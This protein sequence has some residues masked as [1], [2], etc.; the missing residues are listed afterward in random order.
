LNNR[1]SSKKHNQTRRDCNKNSLLGSICILL[2]NIFNHQNEKNAKKRRRHVNRKKIYLHL[3]GTFECEIRLKNYTHF[4]VQVSYS[5]YYIATNNSGLQ[6]KI[7]NH[8]RTLK[9]TVETSHVF[10]DRIGV[11]VRRL[12]SRKPFFIFYAE[13]NFS[14]SFGGLLFFSD[15]IV[16]REKKESK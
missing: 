8:K 2:L 16:C 5:R 7:S 9:F 1:S 4:S 10:I 11:R 6:Q 15:I 14:R 13:K 3:E 12:R